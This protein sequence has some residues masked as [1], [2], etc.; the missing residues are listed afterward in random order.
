MPSNAPHIAHI[1]PFPAAGGVESGALR[2]MQGAQGRGWRNTALYIYIK[3]ASAVACHCQ[4]AGFAV[5][6]FEPVEMSYLHP[7]AY[8]Q[9]AWQ[10]A[11][12]AYRFALS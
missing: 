11:R 7:R 8:L 1:L 4:V 5:T 3:G 9:N 12:A 2:L 10:L 6:D